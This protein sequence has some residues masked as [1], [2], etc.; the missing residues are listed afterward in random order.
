MIR[1]N[2]VFKNFF[3]IFFLLS[4]SFFLSSCSSSSSIDSKFN[5]FYD[6]KISDLNPDGVVYIDSWQ[7]SEPLFIEV[8]NEMFYDSD[9]FV[10]VPRN[11]NDFNVQLDV[12]KD[13]FNNN[14]WSFK[15]LMNDNFEDVKTFDTDVFLRSNREYPY[16]AD[17]KFYACSDVHTFF[18]ESVCFEPLNSNFKKVCDT[19]KEY[20]DGQKAPIAITSIETSSAGKKAILKFTI[21]NKL[22]GDVYLRSLSPVEECGYV[23]VDDYG[24]V[25]LDYVKIGGENIDLSSCSS[26]IARLG[27][28]KKYQKYKSYTFECT[29]DKEQFDFFNVDSSFKVNVEILLSYSYSMLVKQEHIVVKTIPGFSKRE[30][31]DYQKVLD[32]YNKNKL[33]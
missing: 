13:Y 30:L 26:S 2:G 27:F 10:I 21:V 12:V 28:D 1:K 14:P 31:N 25:K 23:P 8:K 9:N 3:L 7:Y 6:V 18:S 16:T 17:V 29:V 20:F 24:K 19:N 5:S 4:F 32:E 22:D 11:Y 15:G 33:E